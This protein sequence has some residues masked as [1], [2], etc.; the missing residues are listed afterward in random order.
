MLAYLHAFGLVL[1]GQILFS[2]RFYEHF[3]GFLA[4]KIIKGNQLV[5]I[6]FSTVNLKAL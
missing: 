3:K 1:P 6:F 4:L 5:A 2:V